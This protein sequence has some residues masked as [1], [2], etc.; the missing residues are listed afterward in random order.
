MS[1][2][3]TKQPCGDCGHA[4]SIHD[5]G[6]D[7]AGCMVNE[8]SCRSY[9]EPKAAPVP[10]MSETPQET[11]Q[12]WCEK[13][14][15]HKS[16]PG[17]KFVSGRLLCSRDDVVQLL[18]PL[19]AERDTLRAEVAQAEG[20]ARGYMLAAEK[21][22]AALRQ[23][24]AGHV[25]PLSEDGLTVWID[26]MGDVPLALRDTAERDALKAEVARLRDIIS[27]GDAAAYEEG[28]AALQARLRGL[29][30]ALLDAQHQ[31]AQDIE[32][33]DKLGNAYDAAATA[34][35]R[36]EAEYIRT[37]ARLRAAL[38]E[39]R[40][41]TKSASDVFLIRISS[42]AAQALYPDWRSGGVKP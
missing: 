27:P 26:G 22:E 7:A 28:M 23:A 6:W 8:C 24:Q 18:Q 36:D 38:E 9:C 11:A 21:A 17:T 32:A 19:V 35:G 29:E 41:L 33:L 13:H 30:A 20:V 2:T 42:V 12:A 5:T 40:R 3:P 34:W 16:V 15:E 39:V 1:E 25:V 4:L 31:E 37:V 10:A 14:A